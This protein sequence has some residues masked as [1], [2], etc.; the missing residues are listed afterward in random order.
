MATSVFST[1]SE[2]GLPRVSIGG[3][4]GGVEE[5]I[6]TFWPFRLHRW[7]AGHAVLAWAAFAVLAVSAVVAICVKVESYAESSHR[8]GTSPLLVMA[9]LHAPCL[10]AAV[11]MVRTVQATV[12]HAD[13]AL[14]VLLRADD[15]CILPERTASLTRWRA[16]YAA[17]GV[18]WT[19]L[20]LAQIAHATLSGA[21]QLSATFVILFALIVAWWAVVAPW[22]FSLQIAA[23][24]AAAPVDAVIKV[25]ED[26]E[27]SSD[28]TEQQWQEL[29]CMPVRS[30]CTETLSRLSAWGP[31]VAAAIVSVVLA[32]LGVAIYSVHEGYTLGYINAA[33]DALLIPVAIGLIPAAVSTR[34]AALQEGLN[35][36]RFANLGSASTADAVLG[37]R[38][39]FHGVLTTESSDSAT[40][41]QRTSSSAEVLHLR[42]S[43]V[44]HYIS[45]QNKGGGLGFVMLGTVVTKYRLLK[46]AAIVGTSV[47]SLVAGLQLISHSLD[48]DQDQDMHHLNCMLSVEQQHIIN[49]ALVLA[50][51]SALCIR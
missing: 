1:E 27:S 14:A 18:L 42:I 37:Q 5:I 45:K 49:D 2:A 3:G 25:V 41:L 20:M 24:L 7:L 17:I 36:L 31:S 32:G 9:L 10:P 33:F 44:E 47:S 51:V 12:V 48:K 50:N 19:G 4:G 30:L 16:G 6:R 26:P 15:R 11:M 21:T 43:V 13:G 38:R 22:I 35:T 28:M 40:L 46:V 34:C 29:V 8:P 39:E 23:T